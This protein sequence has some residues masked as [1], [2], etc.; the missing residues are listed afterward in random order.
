MVKHIVI[1]KLKDEAEGATKAENLKKIKAGLE[2]L[3]G[4]VPML[5]HIEVGINF[6]QSAGCDVAL[7]SEFATKADLEA[8]QVHPDHV[9]IA[10]FIRSVVAARTVADYEV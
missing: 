4:K 10:S 7:Y 3:K 2:A 9:A 8:Y 5:K 1:W 6:E